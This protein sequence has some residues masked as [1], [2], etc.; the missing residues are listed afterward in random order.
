[1][2]N[3]QVSVL[4]VPFLPSDGKQM[5]GPSSYR[6][7]L[8]RSKR[9]E[10]VRNTKRTHKQY[11]IFH[12]QAYM[13]HVNAGVNHISTLEQNYVCEG[14]LQ[15]LYTVVTMVSFSQLT[16]VA[17]VGTLLI[18]TK[19]KMLYWLYSLIIVL[20]HTQYDYLLPEMCCT[21]LQ[22]NESQH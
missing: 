1:M 7:K 19:Y 4:K 9:K 2:T 10:R 16:L 14:M 8:K 3:W 12:I 17:H 6:K 5:S 11:A 15:Q 20:I 18:T 13:Q 21:V 22:L